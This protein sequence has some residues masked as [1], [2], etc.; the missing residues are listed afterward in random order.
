[1]TRI[2]EVFKNKDNVVVAFLTA[3]DPTYDKTLKYV[4]SLVEAGV[5]ILEL[6][7]PFSDPVAESPLVQDANVRSLNNL[8]T[9][10]DLF[11]LI[12]KINEKYDLPIIVKSYMNPVFHYGYER[13]FSEA[14]EAGVDGLLIP[15]APYLE[16]GEVKE[17]ASKYE[18]EIIA[19]LV[20]SSIK[21][22]C[23][24][25]QNSKGYGYL[26]NTGGDINEAIESIKEVCELPIIVDF[27]PVVK[28]N[29]YLVENGL[30]SLI[31]SNP[32]C[33]EELKK[34]IKE[35]KDV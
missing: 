27:N 13:F 21:R 19:I 29:G 25:A 28:S 35:V 3:G 11:S 2:N 17:V 1:M 20:S 8:F 34:V 22:S 12:K 30:V 10:K 33:E 9:T 23:M 32:N 7:L 14:K 26:M 31:A 6:G 18:I 4:D 24:I 16:Q 15:D 5:D